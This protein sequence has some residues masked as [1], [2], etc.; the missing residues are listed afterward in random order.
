MHVILMLPDT[1]VQIVG[2]ANVE[3]STLLAC[4][5]VDVVGLQRLSFLSQSTGVDSRFRG[6]DNGSYSKRA[7]RGDA[8]NTGYARFAVLAGDAAVLLH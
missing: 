2:Y 7:A 6:N 3:G 1:V 4:H 5:D 8:L